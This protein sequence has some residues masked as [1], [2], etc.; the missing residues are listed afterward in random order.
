MFMFHIIWNEEKCKKQLKLQLGLKDIDDNFDKIKQ[1]ANNEQEEEED[2]HITLLDAK[3]SNMRAIDCLK[4]LFRCNFVSFGDYLLLIECDKDPMSYS[5]NVCKIFSMIDMKWYDQC[6]EMPM[7]NE[8]YSTVL[9]YGTIH[10]FGYYNEITR[11][12]TF[13]IGQIYNLRANIW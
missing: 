2:F 3:N 6:Y 13:E 10:F 9:N 11:H 4:S 5:N 12:F 7:V 8:F 1:N